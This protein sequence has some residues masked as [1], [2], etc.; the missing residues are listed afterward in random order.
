ML[1]AFREAQSRRAEAD[2]LGVHPLEMEFAPFGP[3]WQREQAER[4]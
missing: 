2:R 4:R 1:V 3:A